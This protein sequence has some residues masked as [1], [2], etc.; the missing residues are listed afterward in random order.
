MLEGLRAV[1][2]RWWPRSWTG[3]LS[4]RI[5]GRDSGLAFVDVGSPRTRGRDF[6]AQVAVV[7]M[8]VRVRLVVCRAEQTSGCGIPWTMLL[9]Q[10][11]PDV[12]PAVTPH[13]CHDH[14]LTPDGV[15]G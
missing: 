1:K 10:S 5:V 2:S 8:G 6:H 7:K 3:G 11:A 13:C 14:S 9:L 4:T 12:Q 15:Q